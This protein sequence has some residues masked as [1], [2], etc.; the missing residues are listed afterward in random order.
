MLQYS[1]LYALPPFLIAS[2]VLEPI[3]HIGRKQQLLTEGD[4]PES[5]LG[6][7]DMVLSQNFKIDLLLF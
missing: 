5:L 6:E 7:Y 4:P 3:Q 1:T 2:I